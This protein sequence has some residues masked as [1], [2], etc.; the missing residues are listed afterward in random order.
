[1]RRLI[2][3]ALLGL[4]NPEGRLAAGEE[5]GSMGR[6]SGFPPYGL[7]SLARAVS[8]VGGLGGDGQAEKT[9]QR[10][11]GPARADAGMMA[12]GGGVDGDAGR[13]VGDPGR[14]DRRQTQV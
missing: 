13:L 1:M 8:R 4:L 6:P 12:W 14:R 7:K 9:Y 10:P 3:H 5:K 11:L 2:P